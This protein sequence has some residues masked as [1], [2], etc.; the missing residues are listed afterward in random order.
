MKRQSL[1]RLHKRGFMMKSVLSF[2]FVMS[3]SAV[4]N[5]QSAEE[6]VELLCAD[7]TKLA[8][9]Y[10]SDPIDDVMKS[11]MREQKFW[12]ER[13]N[14]A[15]VTA[16][17]LADGGPEAVQSKENIGTTTAAIKAC[18]AYYMI[19]AD[20][21]NYLSIQKC[22]DDQGM[23]FDIEEVGFVCRLLIPN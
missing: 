1:L 19:E 12:S 2:L 13:A 23:E 15:L 18:K 4:A 22:V 11:K 8:E 6:Y 14:D 16:K 20:I 17:L 9:V 21:K 7:K 10:S 3:L 5:A